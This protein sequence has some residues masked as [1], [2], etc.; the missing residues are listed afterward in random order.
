MADQKVDHLF[1][2]LFGSKFEITVDLS[3]NDM[4]FNIYVFKIKKK[5][6]II[7]EFL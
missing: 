7:E 4:P 6:N 3:G 2:P 1:L 5:D